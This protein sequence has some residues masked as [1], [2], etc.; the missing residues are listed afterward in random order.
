MADIKIYGTLKNDTGEAIAYAD[1]VIERKSG[2]NV[3][4]L[5]AASTGGADMSE[6][7]K[8]D[9]LSERLSETLVDVPRTALSSGEIE[10]IAANM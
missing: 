8:H 6:Y 3:A 4:E 1:E 5:L 9:E 7:V 10:A 2:R